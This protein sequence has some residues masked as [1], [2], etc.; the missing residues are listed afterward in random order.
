MSLTRS[1]PI[2]KESSLDMVQLR[3]NKKRSRWLGSKFPMVPPKNAIIRRPSVGISA[4]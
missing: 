4:R 3:S 2:N 1:V